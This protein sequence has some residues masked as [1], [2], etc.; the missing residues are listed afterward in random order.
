MLNSNANALLIFA[1]VLFFL[2]LSQILPRD[3]QVIAVVLIG[4]AACGCIFGVFWDAAYQ[5]QCQRDHERE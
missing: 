1:L 3:L 2:W 4:I 5:E